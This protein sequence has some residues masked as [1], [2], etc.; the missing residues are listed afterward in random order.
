MSI[1][2]GYNGVFQCFDGFFHQ[3]SETKL[4]SLFGNEV[5]IGEA[6]ENE[7]LDFGLPMIFRLLQETVDFSGYRFSFKNSRVY[8]FFARRTPDILVFVDSTRYGTDNESD[9][10]APKMLLLGKINQVDVDFVG[11]FISFRINS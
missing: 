9:C 11:Y 7:G 10:W 2:H 3:D 8:L 6:A 5:G 1:A 4:P